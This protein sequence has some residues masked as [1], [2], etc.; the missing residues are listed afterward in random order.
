[1]TIDDLKLDNRT[2]NALRVAGI[3]EVETLA[4]LT[5]SHLRRIKGLGDV[6]LNHLEQVLTQKGLALFPEPTAMRARMTA[7]PVLHR[8]SERWH[9]VDWGLHNFEISLLLN[10]PETWVSQQRNRRHTHVGLNQ[11]P[12]ATHGWAAR[13]SFSGVKLRFWRE[14]RGW[15]QTQC[16]QWIGVGRNRMSEWESGFRSPDA[17]NTLRLCLLLNI[18]A[19]DLCE[20]AT[21]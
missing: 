16:E 8:S 17:T 14:K 5:R 10:V 21:D 18:H 4:A 19:R 6:S 9:Y 2:Y 20:R 12:Q 3:I 13:Y 7:L 11:I 15:S 1:M